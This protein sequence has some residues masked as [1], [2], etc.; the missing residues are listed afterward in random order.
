M[1]TAIKQWKVELDDAEIYLT[2]RFIAETKSWLV[3]VLYAQ[4]NKSK[5]LW[6]ESLGRLLGL[7]SEKRTNEGFI[8]SP[9][10]MAAIINLFWE[11][12][13][14]IKMLVKCNLR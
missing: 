14:V 10:E 13:E 2:A 1:Q 6:F 4:G 7:T 9:T 3:N 5:M 8:V 11:D 12:K